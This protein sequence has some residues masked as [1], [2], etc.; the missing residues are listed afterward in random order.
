M[1]LELPALTP[2]IRPLRN[3]ELL[4][5]Y[6]TLSQSKIDE[7]QCWRVFKSVP[8]PR[9]SSITKLFK[10]TELHKGTSTYCRCLNVISGKPVALDPEGDRQRAKTYALRVAILSTRNLVSIKSRCVPTTNTT[11][12]GALAC[13]R[14]H[15]QWSR[16][17]Y[18][19]VNSV[20]TCEKYNI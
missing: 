16:P 10:V 9:R 13:K 6:T 14:K 18:V 7:M 15:W 1:T 19:T 17:D 11:E 2:M 3:T 20:R 8:L 4:S 12:F 5:D